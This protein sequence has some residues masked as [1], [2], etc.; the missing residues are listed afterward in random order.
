MAGGL[1]G[2][3]KL[4]ARIK[5]MGFRVYV[6]PAMRDEGLSIGARPSNL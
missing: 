1:F 3:V 4:N 6:Y 5:K 2:N